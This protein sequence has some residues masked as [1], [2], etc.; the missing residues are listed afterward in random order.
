M[1]HQ[2][3]R[4]EWYIQKNPAQKKKE[5]KGK[6][7]TKKRRIRNDLRKNRNVK[8]GVARIGALLRN[9]GSEAGKLVG[10]GQVFSWG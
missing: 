2:V 3:P 10:R 4:K 1:I 9:V 5:D 8:R 7:K 6:T